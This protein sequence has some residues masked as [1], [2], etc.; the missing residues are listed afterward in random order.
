MNC[1]RDVCERQV[2]ERSSVLRVS[3]KTVVVPAPAVAQ[4]DV[5]SMFFL[6]GKH[7]VAPDALRNNKAILPKIQPSAT[8]VGALIIIATVGDAETLL[9]GIHGIATNAN[10]R[11]DHGDAVVDVTI[12]GHKHAVDILTA[13]VIA[14]AV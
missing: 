9:Q 11:F 3:R 12:V 2:R 10:K 4:I 7:A 1:I 8:N 14:F 5:E 6:K 13:V